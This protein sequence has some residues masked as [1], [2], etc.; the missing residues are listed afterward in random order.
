VVGVT[1]GEESGIIET[2]GRKILVILD[3]MHDGS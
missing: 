3:I 1:L 2:K